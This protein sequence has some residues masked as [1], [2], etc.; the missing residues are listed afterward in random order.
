MKIQKTRFGWL[1]SVLLLA[2]SVFAQN[3][4]T[5]P[6]RVSGRTGTAANGNP[7]LYWPGASVAA[8]FEGTSLAVKLNDPSGRAFY[9]VIIDGKDSSP[10]ILDMQQGENTYGAVSNLANGV[11]SVLLY[12]RT[13]GLDGPTE[14]LGFILDDGATLLPPPAA[15]GRRIEFYGDSITCGMGDEAP[16]DGPDDIN[17]QRNNY[18]AYG[19]VTARDLGADYRCIAR[20]GIGIVKS[21]FDLTMPDYWYRLDPADPASRWDFS[22]WTPDVV[23]VNLFQNDNSLIP[24]M[25]PVPGAEQIIQ[26]YVDFISGIRNVYPDAHIVCALGSMNAT[27]EGSLWPGY[28]HQAVERM[29]DPNLSELI[30]PNTGWW[31]HPRIR[32]HREMADLLTAHLRNVMRWE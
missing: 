14:F 15:P 24:K 17:S 4:V 5:A 9:N 11:H 2:G 30:F 20:S 13:E 10:V 23:V 6:V 21:W 12:R 26:A 28:I 18:V 29:N 7:I 31:K 25:D 19:A 27:I 22:T 8:C 1:I 32:H 3:I 16:D